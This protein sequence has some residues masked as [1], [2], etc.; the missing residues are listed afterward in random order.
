MIF[1]VDKYNVCRV[2]IVNLKNKNM[3][4]EVEGNVRKAFRFVKH[5]L[6]TI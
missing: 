2:T 4:S 6:S 5:Y 3:Y 1:S